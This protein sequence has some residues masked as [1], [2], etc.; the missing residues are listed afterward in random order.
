[1]HRKSFSAENGAIIHDAVHVYDKIDNKALKL[2]NKPPPRF[3]F[4]LPFLL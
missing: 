2:E 3:F 1:M 4:P